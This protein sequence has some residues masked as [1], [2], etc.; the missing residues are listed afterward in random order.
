MAINDNAAHALEGR[1]LKNKWQILSKIEPKPGASGGF[2]S[3]CYLVKDIEKGQEAFLKALNF[4]AFFQ[5][6]RGRPI[7]EIINEQTNAFKF[8]REL[9][10][11][12]K[13][14]R[15]TKVSTILDEGEEYLD[16]FTISNVPYLIFEM[17]DG[18]VRSH[19]NFSRNVEISWKLKS[20]HDVA[21]GLKQLHS[22]D[23]G[24]QDLKPSNVL[25]FEHGV[26]SK[27]GDLGRSLCA[28]LDAPHD[29]GHDFPGDLSYAPLEYLYYYIEPDWTKRIRS[30]DMYLFGSLISFFFTGSNMTSLIGKNIDPQF[31]WDK[32]RGDYSAV[33][34]YLLDG[35]YK[36]I[37]EFKSSLT[38][39]ILASKLSAILEYCCYPIPEKRGH[40]KAIAEIGNQY[41]FQRTITS[42]DVLAK[43][44]IMFLTK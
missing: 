6:F 29:N 14:G 21:V 41:D 28:T 17:A 2:F 3:V 26:L 31:K 44:S 11:R 7:V 4:H 9:L 40:P 10:L 32:W 1:V 18:D 36:A 16:E 38:D 37:N 24:H 20:L 25:L 12:C 33:K 39:P 43:K 19:L 27:I 22:L 5:L 42:F 8:E 15:L 34:D 35:F 13:N 30:T 23:I